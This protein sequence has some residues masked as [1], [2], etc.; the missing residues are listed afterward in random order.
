MEKAEI[1][2]MDYEEVFSITIT[3]D[4]PILIGQDDIVGRR[5]LIPIV[6][7]TVS[8]NN[9]NGKVLPGGIDSQVIRPDGKCELSARYAI[10]LDDG[11]KIYIENNGIRTVP[12]EYIAAVKNGEFVDPNA[13]YFRTIPTFETYSQKYKW[14]MN[15]IFVC[16]ATRLPE[17][18][19]LKFYKIS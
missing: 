11:N 5:Q 7:G 8:G 9:F 13:Y 18:V 19:L 16:Y 17:N 6:S 10:E 15:H 4:T 3:V 14:L 2:E 1:K 12:D